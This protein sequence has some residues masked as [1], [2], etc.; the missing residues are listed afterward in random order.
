[1]KIRFFIIALASLALLQACGSG[2]RE[3]QMRSLVE[4]DVASLNTSTRQAAID[5]LSFVSVQEGARAE[6][7]ISVTYDHGSFKDRFAVK[8]TYG[9]E[10]AEDAEGGG[11][12]LRI[13][14]IVETQ[15]VYQERTKN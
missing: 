4:R 6:A 10:E 1:M 12:E 15:P 8:R 7:F 3:E 5:S 13:V 11:R 2:R 9:F 14:S